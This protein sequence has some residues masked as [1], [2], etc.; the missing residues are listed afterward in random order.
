MHDSHAYV[1]TGPQSI[2]QRDKVRTIGQVIGKNLSW[3]EIP[4]DQ[5]RQ[6]MLARGLP[7]DVPDRLLGYLADHVQKPGPSSKT[8]EQILQRPALTFAEWAAEHAAE[9]Q[10]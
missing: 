3:Q 9:F 8:V 2:S 10:N 4:P 7:E 1:L 6:A 5:I